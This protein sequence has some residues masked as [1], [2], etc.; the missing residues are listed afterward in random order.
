MKTCSVSGVGIAPSAKVEQVACEGG[1]R[2]IGLFTPGRVKLAASLL[3]VAALTAPVLATPPDFPAIT[4]AID[5]ASIVEVISTY[6]GSVFVLSMGVVVGW[7]FVWRIFGRILG[8]V[9]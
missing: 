5:V 2:R 1:L 8:R 6:G 4:S 7:V 9:G 3:G